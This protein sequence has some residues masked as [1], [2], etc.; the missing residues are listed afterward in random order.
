M[1][2]KAVGARRSALGQPHRKLVHASLFS[3]IGTDIMAMEA[4]PGS[5]FQ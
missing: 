3:G 4:K 5:E 2:P 1:V